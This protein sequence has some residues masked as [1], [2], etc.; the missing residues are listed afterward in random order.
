[1]P[2]S[3]LMSQASSNPDIDAIWNSLKNEEGSPDSPPRQKASNKPISTHAVVAK[4][5]LEDRSFEDA[6]DDSSDVNQAQVYSGDSDDDDV[7]PPLQQLS[8]TTSWRIE[9]I[10]KALLGSDDLSSRAQSLAKLK[11]TIDALSLHQTAPPHLNYPPPYSDGQIKLNH[12]TLPLVSDL[13]KPTPLPSQETL[14]PLIEGPQVTKHDDSNEVKDMLQATLD[15]C[16][17][18]LF[19]L[20]QNE[21]EKC[22]ALSLECLQSLLLAGLDLRRHIPYMIPALCARFSQCSYDKDLEVFVSDCKS[23]DFY[24]RGGAT[25]HQDRHGLFSQGGALQVIEPTEELRLELCRTLNCLLRGMTAGGAERLLDA[26]YPEVVFSLQTSLRDPFPQVKIETCH[27]LVQLLRIP[28]WED[29]AKYF[30][31]GLARSVLP[32][33]RHKN[34]NVIIAAMDLLESSVCVPNRTKVKGAGTAAI[35]DLVGF[36]EEN[37]SAC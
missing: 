37:V 32:N 14:K 28:H 24:K 21:S 10:G 20:L 13:V 16:G 34:T 26:Y 2:P 27:L 3:L 7:V 29:G 11:V 4:P 22:R 35:A 15:V 9:R 12:Q 17:K 30:A 1:M 18:S 8:G 36:R 33:C 5:T 25:N 6:A 31:T 19:R 23:H